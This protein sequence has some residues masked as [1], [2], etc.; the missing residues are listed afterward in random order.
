MA[1]VI[2]GLTLGL[3]GSLGN[4]TISRQKDGTSTAKQKNKKSDKPRTL[5][6]LANSQ[7]T[8]V[9]SVFSKVIKEFVKVGFALQ[10]KREKIND[11]FN[12]MVKHVRANALTGVYPERSVD[13][14]RVLITKG[15][16]PGPEDI[17]VSLNEFGL[18]FTWN[19]ETNIDGAHYT[20]QVMMVAHFPDLGKAKFKT[21]GSERYTGKD[22]LSLTGIKRGNTADIFISFIANDHSSISDS[23][24]LGK[25]TW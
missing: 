18:L 25:I 13:L 19:P 24:Y 6:Q 23:V 16:M 2:E 1:K 11:P 17:T 22:L 12:S 14:T 7:N 3:S 20:D 15:T 4:M 9:I 5:G 10:A 21:A 8:T